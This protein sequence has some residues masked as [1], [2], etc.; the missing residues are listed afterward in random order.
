MALAALSLSFFNC[1][2]HGIKEAVF[3]LMLLGLW[4][5][6]PNRFI[7]NV[8]FLEDADNKLFVAHMQYCLYKDID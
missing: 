7:H 1:S 2:G 8:G 5:L 4:P 3:S 6:K